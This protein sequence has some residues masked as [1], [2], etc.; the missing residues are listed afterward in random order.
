VEARGLCCIVNEAIDL[1]TLGFLRSSVSLHRGGL[2]LL[3]DLG[4]W[5]K[6]EF[7]AGD[8]QCL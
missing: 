8:L 7:R 1:Y 4:L 3:G 6:E 5:F 2:C